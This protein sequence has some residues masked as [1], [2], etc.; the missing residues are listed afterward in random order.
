VCPPDSEGNPIEVVAVGEEVPSA[1]EGSV[2]LSVAMQ[3]A[4]DNPNGVAPQFLSRCEARTKT[5]KRLV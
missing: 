2:W 4:R 5:R 1:T 3:S